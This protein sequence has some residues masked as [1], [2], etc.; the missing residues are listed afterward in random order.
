MGIIYRSIDYNFDI[1]LT[2]IKKV[3]RRDINSSKNSVVIK[4]DELVS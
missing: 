1:K 3:Y 2:I 4:C